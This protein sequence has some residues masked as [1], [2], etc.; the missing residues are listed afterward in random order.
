MG[1]SW[2]PDG[3]HLGDQITSFAFCLRDC[4][5]IAPLEELD[6]CAFFGGNRI[7]EN[8]FRREQRGVLILVFLFW[9]KCILS[10]VQSNCSHGC[11]GIFLSTLKRWSSLQQASLSA[12]MEKFLGKLNGGLR[13]IL[14]LLL[15]LNVLDLAHGMPEG[16]RG[17]HIFMHR[18]N[19]T[20]GSKFCPLF[21]KKHNIFSMFN[22]DKKLC[23]S[24]GDS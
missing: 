7:R 9:F 22:D 13:S 20:E 15:K 14:S 21:S 4:R 1:F 8:S 23:Q 17:G 16:G 5:G 19:F 3:P 6:Y 10:Y 24:G 18:G 12:S 2:K 11:R